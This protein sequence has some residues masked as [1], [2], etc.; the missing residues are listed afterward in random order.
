MRRKDL[1]AFI[2][3]TLILSSMSLVAVTSSVNV[4]PIFGDDFESGDYSAW[5]DTRPWLGSEMKISGTTVFDGNYSADCEISN[6]VG[7]FAYAYVNFTAPETVVYHREY[8]RIS[9]LP[10]VGA[11]TDLFGIMDHV[12][13]GSHLGTV[14][15]QNEDGSYRWKL[16]YYNNGAETAD[17][18]LIPTGDLKANTWYYIEVMVKSGRGDGEVKVW[19]AED[20]HNIDEAL[21]TIKKSNLVNDDLDIGAVFFGGYVTG[22]PYP[23]HIY[24]DNVVISNIWTGPRDFTN[25][26]AGVI[27]ASSH[28]VGA[29]V[30]VS[31]P[32]NDDFGIDY[33]IP[34]WNNTGEWVNAT[35]IDAEDSLSYT[36]ALT[37]TWNTAPDTVV[38]AVF[39]ANDTSNHW[40]KSAQANFT[41][42]TYVITLSANQTGAVQGDTIN[43]ELAVTKNGALFN[44][45]VANVTKDG[46]LF[47]TNATSGFTDS[48]AAEAGH[49]YTVSSLCDDVVGETV[50]FTSNTLNVNW[51]LKPAVIEPTPTPT[52]PPTATPTPVITPAPTAKPT[53]KPTA[54]PTAKPTS[55][56]LPTTT[57]TPE[58]TEEVTPTP[59]PTQ[60]GLPMAAIIGIAA[61]TLL[62]IVVVTVLFTRRRSPKNN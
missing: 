4:D 43:F 41:L 62:A 42:N 28:S 61:T 35:V 54:Q 5:D 10:P 46:T 13:T 52:P 33:I 39:Y 17:Y 48:E 38:S 15:V 31:C 6:N 34:S 40:V 8:V 20:L 9:S 3:A 30:T 53:V 23:V 51:A 1:Y 59:E 16:E 58:P 29:P 27:S 57:A 45:F 25:P 60:E 11:E 49:V 26:T 7:T 2:L 12:G 44:S 32:I 50:T 56:P 19:I 36:A 22:A 24:S 21:P 18:K 55:T 47:A 14:A 37:G